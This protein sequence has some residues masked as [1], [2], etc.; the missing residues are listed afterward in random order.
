MARIEP[1]ES[2]NAPAVNHSLLRVANLLTLARLLA[3]PLLV[4]LLLRTV[5]EPRFDLYA[6]LAI[7]VLQATDVLDGIVARQARGQAPQGVNPAGEVLDPIADKLYINSAIVT[8]A[9]IGRI[10]WFVAGLIVARDMLILLGWSARYVFSGIR[11]LPN[12]LG[13]AADAS[14]ALLLIVVLLRPG[15]EVVST[16]AWIVVALTILS[17]LS[18]ARMALFEPRG[19]AS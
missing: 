10:E 2:G 5:E 16:A 14:Q 17:G 4:Y 7:I 8:L 19:V 1:A 15:P 12:R 18:Y 13:K 3:T 9:V 6:L 11:L